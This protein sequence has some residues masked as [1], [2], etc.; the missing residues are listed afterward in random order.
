ME[1]PLGKATSQDRTVCP[2]PHVWA[3][4]GAPLGSILAGDEWRQLRT[5]AIS[6]NIP[7]MMLWS[8]ETSLLRSWYELPSENGYDHP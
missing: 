5:A 1:A 6:A 2:R 8:F 4:F 7:K 3:S